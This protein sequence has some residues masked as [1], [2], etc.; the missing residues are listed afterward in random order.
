MISVAQSGKR[1][2][3][4]ANKQFGFG[5]G[6]L[7]NDWQNLSRDQSS[8]EPVLTDLPVE[9]QNCWPNFAELEMDETVHL[10]LYLP[11]SGRSKHQF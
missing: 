6:F 3:C 9:N 10:K 4:L 2:Y 7:N 8:L 5:P 11:F 1:V